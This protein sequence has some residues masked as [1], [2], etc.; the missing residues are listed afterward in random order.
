M[1]PDDASH[2][3]KSHGRK[4]HESVV[5]I[6]VIVPILRNYLISPQGSAS[7]KFAEECHDDQDDG[8]SHAIAYSVKE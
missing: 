8:I 6:S 2:Y 5:G 4:D 3:Y 7:K 1:H